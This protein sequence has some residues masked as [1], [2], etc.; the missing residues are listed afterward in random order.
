MRKLQRIIHVDDDDSIRAVAKIALERV[1]KF[2]LLSCTSGNEALEKIVEF[3][4]EMILLDVMMPGMDGPTTLKNLKQT[5]DLKEVAVVFMTAKVQSA[6]IEYYKSIGACN[7]VLKPFDAMSL[8][9]QLEQYWKEF[10]E[11]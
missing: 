8:S 3:A 5:M 2:T 4:P 6:E 10:N 9:E 11:Q 1:G 7:V